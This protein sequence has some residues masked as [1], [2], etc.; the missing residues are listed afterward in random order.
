[1]SEPVNDPTEKDVLE[2]A[3]E[4]ARLEAHER[5]MRAHAEI[6]AVLRKYNCRIFPQ[7]DPAN[8]EPVGVRGDRLQ[9]R[10]T[11][12]IFPLADG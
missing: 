9:L 10:A 11:Y 8:A 1:M 6:D 7:L 4:D 3:P 12:G 2:D 5:A